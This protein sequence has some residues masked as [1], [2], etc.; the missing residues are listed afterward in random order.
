MSRQKLLLKLSAY[1]ITDNILKWIEKLLSTR[2]QQ[3]KVGIS[4]SDTVSLSS[5][6]VQGSVLGPLLFLLYINDVVNV[7]N[8]DQCT[9]KMY[10]MTSKCTQ[11]SVPQR[12]S[13]LVF[14]AN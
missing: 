5:G 13:Q 9:F 11:T 3:T 8:C 2:I 7:L 14:S 6:V 10:G 12:T 4:L 1:G